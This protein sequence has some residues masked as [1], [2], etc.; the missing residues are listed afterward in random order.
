MRVS[1]VVM[2]FVN[3]T[4]LPLCTTWIASAVTA[5]HLSKK[6]VRSRHGNE[7]KLKKVSALLVRLRFQRLAFAPLAVSFLEVLVRLRNLASQSPG[8]WSGPFV[9]RV[10]FSA[11]TVF[12]CLWRLK[13]FILLLLT[14]PTLLLWPA[15]TRHHLARRTKPLQG[16]RLSLVVRLL[17]S[18][19]RGTSGF[20]K[21]LKRLQRSRLGG[22][23]PVEAER[24]ASR[25][26]GGRLGGDLAG[27]LVGESGSTSVLERLLS[28]FG[29]CRGGEG[30]RE[31][32]LLE[33]DL[34]F[35]EWG[36]GRG[37]KAV[38]MVG[39]REQRVVDELTKR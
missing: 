31:R 19:T 11:R 35:F 6:L 27:A 4:N 5:S 25:W 7:G 13:V 1:L 36:K 37:E 12:F 3:L 8:A 18:G 32:A 22:S 9:V 16:E 39:G 26:G 14:L 34:L 2:G 29:H 28:V 38:R 10:F 17:L 24:R 20:A 21:G 30:E 15:L 33:V 23:C